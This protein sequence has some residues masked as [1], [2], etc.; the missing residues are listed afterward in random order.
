MSFQ[1]TSLVFARPARRSLRGAHLL[2]AEADVPDPPVSCSPGRSRASLQDWTPFASRMYL[3]WP[4]LPARCCSRAVWRTSCVM[5]ARIGSPLP[6]LPPDA[7]RSLFRLPHEL[8]LRHVEVG[9]RALECFGGHA[10]R[11]GEGRVR[12]DGQADILGVRAHLDGER[13]LGD[14]IASGGADDAAADDAVAWPR[15][16]GPWSRPS[17]RPKRQRAAGRGPGENALAVL[18][19]LGLGLVLGQAD[20]GDFGVGVGDRGDDLGVEEAFLPAAASAATLP[21]C[22]ALWASIGW[23]TTSP[24]AKMCG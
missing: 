8:L 4:C 16:T 10:D 18:D 6:C 17:S 21:S 9:D 13:C 3:I 23:P 11:F 24:M 19:A 1:A 14:E 12:V 22:T 7:L 20:P 15:R 5:S 2:L